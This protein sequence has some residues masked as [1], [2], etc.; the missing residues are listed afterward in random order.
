MFMLKVEWQIC[1]SGMSS[2]SFSVVTSIIKPVCVVYACCT[3]K[4]TIGTYTNCGYRLSGHPQIKICFQVFY[5]RFRSAQPKA[6]ISFPPGGLT[7]DIE[8][9]GIGGYTGGCKWRVVVHC[10]ILREVHLFSSGRLKLTLMI[11]MSYKPE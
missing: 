1:L 5:N 9:C 7:D 11:M 3:Y 8:N 6:P 2:I 10:N 4:L